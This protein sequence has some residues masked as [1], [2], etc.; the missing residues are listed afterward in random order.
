MPKFYTDYRKRECILLSLV[1]TI[2]PSADLKIRYGRINSIRT[3]GYIQPLLELLLFF[4]DCN[5]Q[6]EKL[7][8]G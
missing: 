2:F 3:N 7:R 5:Y 1:K 6:K 8:L 4:I